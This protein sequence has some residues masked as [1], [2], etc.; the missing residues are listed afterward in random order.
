MTSNGASLTHVLVHP[1]GCD[2]QDYSTPEESECRKSPSS[3]YQD[4]DEATVSH[5]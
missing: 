5:K 3:T 4:T 2:C 1:P